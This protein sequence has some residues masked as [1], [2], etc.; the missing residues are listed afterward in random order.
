MANQARVTVLGDGGWGTALALVNARKQNSVMLWSAFA[1]YA[2]VLRK[3]REN[4]KFLPGVPLPESLK[5]T[6]DM[7]E[8][9]EFGD[10]II[11][12]IPTQFLRNVLHKLKDLPIKNKIFVSVAKG[13]EKKTY[14]RPSEIV[15]SV[16]GES[17]RLCILSGPSHAEEVARGIPTLVVVAS[18]DPEVAREVQSV[19]GETYLRTYVQTDEVGVE[20]G[21]ALKNVVAIAAGVSDGLGFGD[22]TKSGLI[23]RGLLEMARLG[24][25]VGAN[26]NTFYGLSGLGDLVTTCFSQH[27]RNLRV[28]RDL[29]KGKKI[30]EIL[31]GMEMVAEGVDTAAAVYE[32]CQ[33]LGLD[34]PIMGEVYRILF[35]NKNP[36]QAVIDLL[37]RDVREEWKQY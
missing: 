5:I 1:E 16:L 28:G 7:K 27:G 10:I 26:P 32:F 33:K 20:L 30:Q 31:G 23:S 11:L 29:G 13:I 35:E 36:R 18:R 21:G 12:A 3:K 34:L 17:V 15:R 8:A 2:E 14:L 24:I 19:V 25:R 4:V 6:S 9:V 22:N 37:N